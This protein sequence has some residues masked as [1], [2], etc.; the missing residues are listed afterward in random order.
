MKV[1]RLNAELQWTPAL[2]KEMLWRPLQEAVLGKHSTTEL[3]KIGEIDKIH[4]ILNKVIIERTQ[5]EVYVPF[6]SIEEMMKKYELQNN[7]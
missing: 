6:P 2:V 5:G 1:I 4:E 3:L 7:N